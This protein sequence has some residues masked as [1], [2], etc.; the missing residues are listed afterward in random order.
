MIDL[1]GFFSFC[2]SVRVS[3]RCLVLLNGD[4]CLVPKSGT[5]SVLGLEMLLGMRTGFDLLYRCVG[6]VQCSKLKI[7]SCPQ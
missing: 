3:R 1:R 2:F 4:L 6:S 7:N 5:C